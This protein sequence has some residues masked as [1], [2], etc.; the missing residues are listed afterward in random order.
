MLRI[1][2]IYLFV[3]TTAVVILQSILAYKFRKRDPKTW[4]LHELQ[5]R[6]YLYDALGVVADFVILASTLVVAL[7]TEKV[8]LLTLFTTGDENNSW[9]LLLCF[10]AS[11]TASLILVS[12]HYW[13]HNRIERKVAA[14]SITE[15]TATKEDLVMIYALKV[16]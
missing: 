9:A 13:L 11:L 15:S 3:I 5:I 16:G 2:W 8:L 4:E 14:R 12:V 10:I 1:V 6:I 7:S